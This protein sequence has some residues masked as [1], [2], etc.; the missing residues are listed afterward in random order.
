[1]STVVN[2]IKFYEDEEQI[3]FLNNP[4]LINVA[5][6]RAKKRLYIL[7]SEE[8]LNQEGSILRDLAKYY[9]YYCNE[10]KVLKTSVFSVFDLMY[11]D[12]A[13]I[14][15]KTKK[16]LLNISSFSSENII[17]TVIDEICKS[18]E[19]G[20]LGY[21]FNYPLK[22]VIKTNNLSDPEDV[23]FVSNINTHCDFLIYNQLNKEIEMVVEVDGSQHREEVQA[24]RDTRKDRLLSNA[25][26]K[27]LRLST[28]TIE[29]KEKI[30]ALLKTN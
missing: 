6:S 24:N 25:G 17:A 26:I 1:M 14:L 28:T 16:N 15:E 5:I 18:G 27:V 7:A 13:P 3:D 9:E 21:K 29:C 8:V 22:Y 2:K 10:T 4:N 30:L 19:C 20:A 11:D 12:Y 23:K